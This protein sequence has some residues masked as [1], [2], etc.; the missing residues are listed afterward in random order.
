MK[1]IKQYI[2]VGLGMLSLSACGDFL[3]IKPQNEIVL[4][5]YWTEKA[6]ATSMLMSC[7]DALG[8]ENCLR[9]IA[10]WGEVR[11]D[12]MKA[13][14]NAPFWLQDILKENLQPTNEICNWEDI[15]R[16]INYCNTFIMLQV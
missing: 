9:R 10:L 7:Y 16:T 15:Y 3:D 2:M 13:G 8:A 1:P 11:S 14:T 5:D 6:D 4:E 12:N